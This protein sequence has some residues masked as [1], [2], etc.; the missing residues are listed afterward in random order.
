MTEVIKSI[1]WTQ[2]GPLTTLALLA[3]LIMLGLAPF[4]FKYLSKKEELSG[5]DRKRREDRE[6]E[7]DR[8][9]MRFIEITG[10]SVAK[11]TESIEKVGQQVSGSEVRI[12]DK[13]SAEGAATRSEIA[14]LRDDL[15]DRR[16]SEIRAELRELRERSSPEITPSTH[17]P[18]VQ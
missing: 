15:D 2:V 6:A 8:A 16:T 3:T 11:M 12:V 13:I 10:A 5:E 17:R 14:K 9:L 1:D 18:T 7:K 4:L